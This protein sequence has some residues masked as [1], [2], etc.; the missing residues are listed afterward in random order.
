M[1]LS[2]GLP[3]HYAS[4]QRQANTEVFFFLISLCPCASVV[5]I[6]SLAPYP[7]VKPQRQGDTEIFP[8]E[9]SKKCVS[10][11]L[12]PPASCLLP[13]ACC[14]LPPASRLLPSAC[15]LLPAASCLP[16]PASCFLPPASCL[17]PPACCLLPVASCLLPP[18]SCFPPPASCPLLLPHPLLKH[19]SLNYPLFTYLC[20]P[21]HQSECIHG[22]LF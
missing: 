20:S 13:P 8:W 2:S 7:N 19:S 15:C 17:P 5:I 4:P 6:S 3:Y 12:L 11:R 1:N 16:P 9:C 10:P 14:L 21:E 22:D 18:A